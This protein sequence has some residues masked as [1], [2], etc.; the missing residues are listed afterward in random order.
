M[1]HDGGVVGNL[2]SPCARR[3]AAIDC[4][5][6][7]GERVSSISCGVV[8]LVG[9]ERYFFENEV[10][11]GDA[12]LRLKVVLSAYRALSSGANGGINSSVL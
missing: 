1:G 9:G 5:L 10:C 6:L 11:V 4:L 7:V 8:S 2:A 3:L 12:G